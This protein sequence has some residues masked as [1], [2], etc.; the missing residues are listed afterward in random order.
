MTTIAPIVGTQETDLGMLKCYMNSLGELK[1][2]YKDC[3]FLPCHYG[4]IKRCGKRSKP[5]H[6]RVSWKS[7]RS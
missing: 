3:Y 4:E 1:H 5:H 7:A 6:S 2:K